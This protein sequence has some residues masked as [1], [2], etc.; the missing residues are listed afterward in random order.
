MVTA[1]KAAGIG[2]VDTLVHELRAGVAS[3]AQAP[4]RID[5]YRHRAITHALHQVVFEAPGGRR[6]AVPFA[7]SDG[8]VTAPFEL[9]ALDPA[10]RGIPCDARRFSLGLISGRHLERDRVVDC[11]VLRNW[12][13]KSEETSAAVEALACERM[14]ELL[15][16]LRSERTT[17]V[18][19]F[20][21]GLEPVVLGCYRAA[22][23]RLRTDRS[24]V[25]VSRIVVPASVRGDSLRRVHEPSLRAL[26]ELFTGFFGASYDAAGRLEE[27][28]WVPER[29][30]LETERD[31]ACREV[32]A[33]DNVIAALAEKS[34][35]REEP[36]W[37]RA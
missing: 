29:E 31:L 19:L 2:E 35:C 32:P 25:V 8:S 3:A 13:I 7:F 15:D 28:R 1:V 6:Q 4:V 12:E 9:P 11:Y 30:M 18:D 36:V 26:C 21:T 17:V 14:T 10:R 20:H 22:I 23:G 37:T 27:V 33:L 5:R 34:R 24:L 16:E